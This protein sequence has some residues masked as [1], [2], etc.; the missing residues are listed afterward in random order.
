MF[1]LRGR[2]VIGTLLRIPVSHKDLA[3]L[4]GATR[5][6]ITEHLAELERKHVLIRQG[7]QLIV[8]LDKIENLTS[9]PA[10]RANHLFAEDNLP[11]FLKDGRLNGLRPPAAATSVRPPTRK[12]FVSPGTHLTNRSNA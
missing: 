4:V 11:Y 5:P 3:D 8:R 12:P 2:R 7:R 9:V 6:R 1:E 10:P